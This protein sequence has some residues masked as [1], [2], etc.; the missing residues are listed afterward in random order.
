MSLLHRRK[1]T[2]ELKASVFA[3]AATPRESSKGF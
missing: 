2:M 1:N 3:D